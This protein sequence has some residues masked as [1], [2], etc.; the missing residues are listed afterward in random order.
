MK[1]F[2]CPANLV[3]ND[4]PLCLDSLRAGK[5]DKQKLKMALTGYKAG[6]DLPFAEW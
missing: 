1:Y 2:M 5:V 6:L 4:I 3:T